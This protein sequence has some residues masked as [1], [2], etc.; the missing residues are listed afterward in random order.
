LISAERDR[1]AADKPKSAGNSIDFSSRGKR[2]S[3]NILAAGLSGH[4]KLLMSDAGRRRFVGDK[5]QLQPT[6]RSLTVVKDNFRM[7]RNPKEEELRKA[8]NEL[9]KKLKALTETLNPTPAKPR[10]RTSPRV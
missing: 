4:Q 8:A 3:R 10:R 2:K 1:E 6:Q 7:S 5:G 9:E